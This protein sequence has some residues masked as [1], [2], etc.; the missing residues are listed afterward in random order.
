MKQEKDDLER[1]ISELRSRLEELRQKRAS[2]VIKVSLTALH[3][4]LP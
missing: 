3:P 1:K 2:M 4:F